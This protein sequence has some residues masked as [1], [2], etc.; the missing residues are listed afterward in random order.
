[1]DVVAQALSI[2]ARQNKKKWRVIGR[3]SLIDVI[4]QAFTLL[5]VLV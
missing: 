4:D 1:V 5:H 3:V 2:R